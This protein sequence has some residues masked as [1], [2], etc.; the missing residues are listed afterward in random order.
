MEAGDRL[1]LRTAGGGA[2][3][4][5]C[6]RAIRLVGE[7]IRSGLLSMRGAAVRHGVVFR[8][9]GSLDYDP[10]KTFKLRS[11]HLTMADV[12]EILD[13]VEGFEKEDVESM[14]PPIL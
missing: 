3:G 13:G 14:E 7:D 1:F 2:Y 9:E 12:E 10:A 8:S 6:E 11:Y 5:P 4:H